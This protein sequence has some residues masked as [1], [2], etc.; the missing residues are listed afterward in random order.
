MKEKKTKVIWAAIVVPDD[1]EVIAIEPLRIKCKNG[2]FDVE[3]ITI[4]GHTSKPDDFL[5]KVSEL[6]INAPALL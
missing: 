6:I 5:K 3:T 4:E 1:K 2:W